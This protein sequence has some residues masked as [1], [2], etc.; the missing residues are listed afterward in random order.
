MLIKQ[1]GQG[2]SLEGHHNSNL[3]ADHSLSV[4]TDKINLN[5]FP[6][7]Q[8]VLFLSSVFSL[9]WYPYSLCLTS[10]FKCLCFGHLLLNADLKWDA[11]CFGFW[12]R[13]AWNSF[14]ITV[15]RTTVSTVSM[16]KTHKTVWRETLGN[17]KDFWEHLSCAWLLNWSFNCQVY[18]MLV[19]YKI[20]SESFTF[21]AKTWRMGLL[22][23]WTTATLFEC[24]KRVML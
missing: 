6:S 8:I 7:C 9:K 12:L 17:H 18:F 22:Y 1:K 15:I 23:Q 14:K 10:G 5:T 19:L 16:E 21:L 2:E 20:K 24:F 4:D 3:T 11:N 13:D